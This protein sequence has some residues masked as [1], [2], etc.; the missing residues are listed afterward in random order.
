MT[1]VK[2]CG[3]TRKEDILIC[4]ELKPDF[5]G[6]VFF[7][8]SIRNV[9]PQTAKYLKSILDKDIQ[10]VGVFVNANIDFIVQLCNENI[11]DIIQLHG[12]EDESYISELRKLTDKPVIKAVKVK[13][14][15]EI[16]NADMLPC[17]YLLLDT[18]IQGVEGGSG[19]AFDWSLI[20]NNLSKPFILAGG[21]TASNV[22]SAISS[23]HPYAVDVSSGVEENLFKSKDKMA[24]FIQ[25]VKN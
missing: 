11:L 8:K 5:I 20:P 14:T 10:S 23:C 21:L 16:L 9:S 3:L 24:E 1:K 4:N 22:A 7:Q 19:S 18:Y 15:S 6:F 12:N 13:N 17:N 25:N 2:I